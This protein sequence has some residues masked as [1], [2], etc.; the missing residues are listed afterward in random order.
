MR[1]ARREEARKVL[2]ETSEKYPWSAA[3]KDARSRL[4][5]LEKSEP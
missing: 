1:A 5:E 2:Q 3:S 4:A